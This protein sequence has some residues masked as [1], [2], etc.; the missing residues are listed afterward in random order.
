MKRFKK[1]KLF[2]DQNASKNQNTS[3]LSKSLQRL[4]RFKKAKPFK[5]QNSSQVKTLQSFKRFGLGW[6][7][8]K[9]TDAIPESKLK[10]QENA[11]V[12]VYKVYIRKINFISPIQNVLSK[13]NLNL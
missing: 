11:T 1:A 13:P 8:V 9:K 7:G 3:K 10:P 2:K 5:N 12:Y 4:K 6:V